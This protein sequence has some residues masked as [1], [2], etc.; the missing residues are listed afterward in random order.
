MTFIYFYT[1]D[2]IINSQP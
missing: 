1:N 2:D